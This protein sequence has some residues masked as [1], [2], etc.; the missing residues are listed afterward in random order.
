MAEY[1]LLTVIVPVFNERNTV[2]EIL[3]RMRLVELPLDKEI[4]VVDDGST[5][6][7][8]KV[9]AAVEDSTVRMLRHPTNQGKGAAIRTGLAAARGDLVLIQDADLEYDPNDW[10]RLLAPLLAGT[11]KVVYG[12]RFSRTEKAT[13]TVLQD[14]TGS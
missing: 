14:R 9:L 8:D 12:T 7:T 2:S 3:R 4:I 6:G 1:R 5:D 10:P 13:L 11:S